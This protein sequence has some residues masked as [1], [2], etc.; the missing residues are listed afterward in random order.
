MIKVAYPERNFLRTVLH[1][2]Q[3]GYGVEIAMSPGWRSRMV[4]RELAS[5]P[6]TAGE[7]DAIK[8]N[9]KRP[10]S[11]R[12]WAA[13]MPLAITHFFALG[14]GFRVQVIAQPDVRV[15]YTRER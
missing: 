9:G 10:P 3:G 8:V 13:M 7:V 15:I 14:G 5:M 2:L 6:A 12:M 1:A 11:F 4:L